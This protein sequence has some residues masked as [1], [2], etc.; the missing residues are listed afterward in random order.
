MLQT[1]LSFLCCHCMCSHSIF[2]HTHS[3]SYLE[4]KILLN[5][6]SFVTDC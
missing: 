3:R 5:T 2:E 4:D 1:V 6:L